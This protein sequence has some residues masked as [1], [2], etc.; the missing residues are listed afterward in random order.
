M[1][2]ETIAEEDVFIDE[3]GIGSGVVGRLSEL[4]IGVNAVNSSEKP[5]NEE[6]YLNKRVE[7][8]E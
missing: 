8:W 5:I 3:I 7:M 4:G 6:L 1:H 2:D